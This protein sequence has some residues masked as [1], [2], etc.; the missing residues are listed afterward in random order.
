MMGVTGAQ[1][2]SAE[3]KTTMEIRP[4]LELRSK[5]GSKI[6]KGSKLLRNLGRFF[7]M[8]YFAEGRSQLIF[9]HGFFVSKIRFHNAMYIIKIYG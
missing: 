8:K 5:S 2:A 6:S 4:R 3:A 1:S 7:A 9:L